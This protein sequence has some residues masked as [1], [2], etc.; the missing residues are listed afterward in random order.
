[1]IKRYE[2]FEVVV[3]KKNEHLYAD[4]GTVPSG[5]RLM[6]PVPIA[7][8]E[9]HAIWTE[10]CQGD[11]SEDELA[12]LGHRLFESLITG[13]IASEWNICLSR[14]RRRR[15]TGLRLRFTVQGDA[16]TEVPL[17][18][19]CARTAPRHEFLALEALSPVVRSPRYSGSVQERPITL[20][21]RVLVVV[22]NPDS[23]TPVDP[24]TERTNL[25][26][27]LADFLE[28]GKLVMDYLGSSDGAGADCDTLYRTLVR[29][30][31]P[32]D[33]A[34]F[35]FH[36]GLPDTHGAEAKDTLCLAGPGS[37]RGQ[38]VSIPDLTSL[39]AYNGVRV[40]ILHAHEG[41]HAGINRAF[42]SMAGRFIAKGLPAVM[43]TQCPMDRD[44]AAWFYRH[45][46]DSW[47]AEGDV[48]L[49][50]AVTEARQSVA[51]QFGDRSSSWWAPVLFA[52]QHSAEVLK[53]RADTQPS[54]I[55]LKRGGMLMQL[56]QIDQAVAELELAYTADPDE[57]S[58]PLAHALVAQ[59]QAREHGG[60]KDGA[61][62]ACERALEVFPDEPAAQEIKVSILVRRGNEALLRDD[63]DS[64]LAA[65]QQAGDRLRIERAEARKREQQQASEQVEEQPSEEAE[66]GLAPI[67]PADIAEIERHLREGEEYVSAADWQAAE[68]KFERGLEYY[69]GHEKP[70]ELPDQMG[71]LFRKL[72]MGQLYAQGMLHLSER[73]WRAAVEAFATLDQFDSTY[74]G[75]DIAARLEQAELEEKREREYNHVLALLAQ[76]SW[77]EVVRLATDLDKSYEGP[78]GR[79]VDDVLKRALY[80]WG[81]ELEEDDPV[82]AYYLF[83]DL[84]GQ[85][86]SYEDVAELCATLAFRNGT[87]EDVPMSWA[88]KVDWLENVVE[89][90]PNHRAGRTRR[91]LDIARH[92]WSE[93]LLEENSPVAIAQL[94]KITPDYGQWVEVSQTLADIYYRLLREGDY[95]R[96]E[97][98]NLNA[99]AEAHS[100]LG[101]ELWKKGDQQ[102]ALEQLARIPQEVRA[103]P[104]MSALAQMYVALGHQERGARRW[105]SALEW[106]DKALSVSPG[107]IESLRWRI[108]EVRFRLWVMSHR[109]VVGLVGAACVV[110]VVA[111]AILRS[112]ST[113]A[114]APP[115]ETATPTTTAIPTSTSTPSVP[116][117]PVLSPTP[118]FTP[119]SV[120]TASPTPILP[121]ATPTPRS[122]ST[123]TPTPEPTA[124]P[125]PPVPI[126]V[127]P[128]QLRPGFGMTIKG[129]RDVTLEWEGSLR[130]GQVFRVIMRHVPTGEVLESPDLTTTTWTTGLATDKYG[131]Y[132]WQVVVIQDGAI[133][134]RTS[135]EWLLWYDPS[136]GRPGEPPPPTEPPP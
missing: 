21:L 114:V 51:G 16:L 115:S 36:S 52:H 92:R 91:L 9:D 29:T 87:R 38:S 97:H 6:Q 95:V 23:Q 71:E 60:D 37:E 81:K 48:P 135:E 25:E 14:A 100:R 83:Y 120:P 26:E 73:R 50:C 119:I 5:R 129:V 8:P 103:F 101:L 122:T 76:E 111:I 59:A 24:V 44:V 84:Y 70:S 57:A 13:A 67:E 56:G 117:A 66:E 20:P 93:E 34:H 27:A 113:P 90:D 65:Y 7:L 121:T 88:Q 41:A 2:D 104:S 126:A 134:A 116:I 4:L 130:G 69:Q 54:S 102:G 106:W 47:L 49:E 94:E 43:T 75:V 11:K 82:R 63:V 132:R 79:T 58:L 10:A 17:E 105:Q 61:L 128:R 108:R 64:A 80:A 30:E 123:A 124:T 31:Y 99:E 18:L 96:T 127:Q 39:M 74:A 15:N 40:V 112:R 1:M 89:I 3:T 55:W 72:N 131:E 68:V 78:D 107:L 133:V 33:I 118:T 22:A 42:R 109:P 46:Y 85:D 110:L 45:C 12:E 77:T 62:V 136:A 28:S 19:L 125:S 53:V 98:S 86:P 35:L 32:Y